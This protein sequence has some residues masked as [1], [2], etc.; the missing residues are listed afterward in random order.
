MQRI[1]IIGRPNVG[2]SS[3]FNRLA[4]MRL[5]ITSDFAG[6]TRDTK[7]TQ[8][9]IN[10]KQAI[11]IDSG[12][13]DESNE[14]F[15]KVYQKTLL[16]A[17]NSDII[18]FMV[19]GKMAPQDEDRKIFYTLCKFKKPIALVINKIDNQK[20][21][22]RSYEFNSFGAKDVFNISVS[23]NSG[24][25]DLKNFI[26][27][28]LAE[29]IKQDDTEL[30]EDI[31]ENIDEDGN[32]LIDANDTIK[33]NFENKNI[34]IGII[35][36][37][38]VG[39]SSLLNALVKEDRSIV[40]SIAGTTIDPVNE[41]IT[42]NGRVLE[43]VDTAG[44]RKRGKIEGIEKFALNRTEKMLEE[45][46]IAL[47][48]LD[49][50]ENFSE[51]DER[52]AGIISKFNLATIIVLNK[53]DKSRQDFDKI[54]KEIRDKFKFL[55][56]APIISVSATMGKR[57]HK[58]YDLI[59]KVYENYTQKIQTSTLNN[60]IQEIISEHK[61]P[62]YKGKAVRIY[63]CT[64]FGFAP[65]KI[66]LVMNRPEALHFSYKRYI[67]N[68]LRDSFNLLGTPVI[69]LPKRRSHSNNEE[70]TDE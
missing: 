55:S 70:A 61:I 21:E 10:S 34:K 24:I 57:V 16:E 66:A 43:F 37:V 14:I 50:S 69:L 1:I 42:Y 13:I 52:I 27:K 11:L 22:F 32:Y 49:A 18:L 48:I 64:Q 58:I 28:F 56:F 26:D 23:H 36:R 65:P 12:G 29:D 2:K 35:G 5:A 33:N 60:V 68:K 6:T 63:Y 9:E 31:L 54:S 4:S 47:L 46:D 59:L 45:A 15:Q 51:L 8:I 30:L 40:S 19:D 17:K 25:D 38:N 20:D 41:I 44:I 3:L 7:K 62:R 53:W 67:L 39:K